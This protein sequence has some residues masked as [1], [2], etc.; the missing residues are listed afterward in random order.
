MKHMGVMLPSEIVLIKFLI[1]AENGNIM[2][3]WQI[4][5]FDL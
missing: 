2:Q 3:Y 1:M 4:L 5:I